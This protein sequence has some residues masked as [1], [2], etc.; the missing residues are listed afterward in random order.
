[1]IIQQHNSADAAYKS[2]RK[3][4][5]NTLHCHLS[6]LFKLALMQEVTQDCPAMRIEVISDVSTGVTIHH[7]VRL[8]SVRP[9]VSGLQQGQTVSRLDVPLRANQ[10]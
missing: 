7:V 8:Y 4:E 6:Q 1:M 10:S 9:P 3:P 2:T 5:V